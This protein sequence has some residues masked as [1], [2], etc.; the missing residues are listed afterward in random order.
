MFRLK[1]QVLHGFKQVYLVDFAESFLVRFRYKNG[2]VF[3]DKKLDLCYNPYIVVPL[4]AKADFKAKNG[5]VLGGF[6]NRSTRL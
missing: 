6:S 1:M 4:Y 3:V 5:C 2:D